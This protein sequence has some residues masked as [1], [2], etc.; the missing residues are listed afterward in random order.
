MNFWRPSAA[1][2][3]VLA[4]SAC[5]GS[6]GGGGGGSTGNNG[7]GGNGGSGS[8]NPTTTTT[9]TPFKGMFV[10]GTVTLA[11]ANGNSVTLLDGSGTI[12]A[13]G[14]AT[15]T[16]AS[17]A[18]YPL[19]VSV[20]GT[21]VDETSGAS[22][23][24]T[25]PVR[26]VIPDATAA[27]AGVAVTA[28]TE[29]AVAKLLKDSPAGTPLAAYNAVSAVT[30][31]ASAVAGQYYAQAMAAPSFNA[32]GKTVQTQTM[33]LAALSVVAAQQGT[34]AE[35]SAKLR[36]L[37]QSLA[38]GSAVA[39]SLPQSR[40]DSAV[41]A[42]NGGANTMLPIGT[43]ALAMPTHTMQPTPLGVAPSTTNGFRTLA[44]GTNVT[45]GIKHDDTLWSWGVDD[46]LNNLRSIAPHPVGS[47]FTA[48]AVGASSAVALKADGTLWAWGYYTGNT[49]NLGS[50]PVQIGTGFTA[51][52]S[53]AYH[54]MAL[55]GDGSLWVWGAN[56]SGQFGDGS[57]N[58]STTL[59]TPKQV[60]TGVA[61]IA[62]GSDHSVALKTDGT[63]WTWGYT[64]FG[65]LG[66]GASNPYNSGLGCYCSATP[67]Q[68][69]SGYA[70]IW[71]GG[72][73][74]IARKTDGSFWAWGYNAYGQIGDGSVTHVLAPKQIG[75]GYTNF[76]LGLNQTL[77]LKSDGSVWAWGRNN[78]G[79]IG[80]NGT[81][82]QL[83]PVQ[84]ASSGF[85]A[86]AT[87]N[88]HSVGTRGGGELWA[89][90]T[91]YTTGSVVSRI[92]LEL[93]SGRYRTGTDVDALNDWPRTSGSMQCITG[94]AFTV[95]KLSGPCASADGNLRWAN[96]CSSANY[97]TA[98]INYL[99]C[100][101]DNST[102]SYKTQYTADYN[103]AVQAGG[104]TNLAGTFCWYLG[105]Q[106]GHYDAFG[107]CGPGAPANTSSV[108]SNGGLSASQV[109]AAQ[110]CAT[111]SYDNPQSR[112]YDPQIDSFCQLAQFD[113][114]LHRATN[115]TTYDTEGRSACRIV[116]SLVQALGSN[117]SCRYCPYP[118]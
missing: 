117:W 81:A 77:A 67:Q 2:L 37:S 46:F 34:G 54:A 19:I 107:L 25:V 35:M 44:A 42:V 87:G 28:I 11:D 68:I 114:C 55:K 8:T 74:N 3:L 36:S 96:Y 84:V 105:T 104:S 71:A 80:N 22:V 20:A 106:P 66:T 116:T 93:S 15:L 38:N 75:T 59:L 61:A 91:G 21:Y 17:S 40:Y 31:A 45:F 72:G 64:T 97:A 12:G 112:P 27:Q 39:Q 110:A 13:N 57:T 24:T 62:A 48:V 69:G 102:G 73:H 1:A 88:G 32:Q 78:A 41:G 50:S 16:Y 5:G 82:D 14:R 33:Q 51:I 18:A 113:A 49:D 118:Y 100:A 85:A 23:A 95:Q 111:E 10:G 98:N 26:G 89:W 47:G 6:G 103:A 9:V 43:A 70:A 30:A 4:L 63:L 99:R 90:G 109:S 101:A 92:P 53:G 76:S 7:S 65:R 29:I 56:L 83:T 58:V 52:A 60:M 86:I 94:G 115:A 108:T 79:Q